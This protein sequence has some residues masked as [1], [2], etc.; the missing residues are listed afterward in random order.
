MFLIK[1]KTLLLIERKTTHDL[2]CS[3]KDG[4]YKEQ[5]FRIKDANIPICIYL[6][7]GDLEFD[8]FVKIQSIPVSTLLSSLLNTMIRDKIMVYK[9]ISLGG[10]MRYNSFMK[11]IDYVFTVIGSDEYEGEGKIPGINAA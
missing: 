10:S 3:I 6:I 9:T 5:K 4:R 11:N 8:F 2:A 1:N 7:E